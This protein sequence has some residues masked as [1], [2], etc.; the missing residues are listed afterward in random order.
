VLAF[1][2]DDAVEFGY[3][4]K[5][6]ARAERWVVTASAEQAINATCSQIMRELRKFIG[7]VLKDDRET[8]HEW[9][10]LHD[11]LS[12]ALRACS[13]IEN[14]G[15]MARTFKNGGQVSEP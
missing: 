4:S 9:P 1:K 7:V 5:Y 8:H 6:L 3:S 10:H 11:L 2:P 12:E 15:M 13:E 14:R